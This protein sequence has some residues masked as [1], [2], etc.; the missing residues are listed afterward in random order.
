LNGLLAKKESD[1][2]KDGN[3]IAYQCP[4]L[5]NGPC[6]R[7]FEDA[8]ILANSKTFGL[9]STSPNELEIEA[10]TQASKWKKSEFALK[11]AISEK[12][13]S[14]PTYIADGLRWLAPEVIRPDLALAL[15]VEAAI[16]L[17]EKGT[18]HD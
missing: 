14:V 12:N 18:D 6:G 8:F 11:Y 15:A 1:K 9:T 16:D 17:P 7:T 13:W 2:I 5:E 4:E 10:R 3:R